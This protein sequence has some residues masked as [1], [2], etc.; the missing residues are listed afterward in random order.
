MPEFVKRGRELT[1]RG[2]HLEA[3]K[4][5][6]LGLLA[7][8]SELDGRLV[9]GQA[10]LSLARFDEVLA[11]MRVALELD[12]LNSTAMA[13]KGEALLGRGD[14]IQA[15]DVLEQ[16]ARF[17]ISDARIDAALARARGAVA[18]GAVLDFDDVSWTRN[19]PEHV[20]YPLAAAAADSSTGATVPGDATDIE[21]APPGLGSERRP[22]IA[23]NRFSAPVDDAPTTIEI[24]PAI[25]GVEVEPPPAFGDAGDDDQE[26][27]VS[28]LIPVDFE[29]ENREVRGFDSSFRA[30]QNEPTHG[31]RGRDADDEEGPTVERPSPDRDAPLFLESEPAR[32][33]R[34][35]FPTDRP[36][37]PPPRTAATFDAPPPPRSP[38]PGAP[39]ET[40]FPEDE[41]GVSKIELLDDETGMPRSFA[42]EPAR[43]RPVPR[44]VLE[45]GGDR[46][47]SRNE[48]M[49]TIRVGLG[50]APDPSRP[51]VTGGGPP[52]RRQRAAPPT[53]LV[54]H[55]GIRAAVGP[56]RRRLSFPVLIALAILLVGGGVSGGVAL[57]SWRTGAQLEAAESRARE[58][59][60]SG[61]YL[62]HLR[63]AALLERALELG[64]NGDLEAL[65]A[66]VEATLHDEFGV[67]EALDATRAASLAGADGDAARARRALA[68]GDA[69]AA[70]TLA[71]QIVAAAPER[72]EGHY[73]R[74]R[75]QV[76][77]GR[78][79]EA[80]RSLA[81]AAE[82]GGTSPLIAAQ[83]AAVERLAGDLDAAMK[84]AGDGDEPALVIE[85]ARALAVA[86]DLGSA[87]EPEASLQLLRADA[88]RPP[89]EQRI[90]VAPRQ[91]ALA[92]L[93]LAEIA[94]ARGDGDRARSEL[95]AL[96]GERSP[97]PAF[98]AA[99]GQALL[100]AG[101]EAGAASQG[102]RL[103]QE[104]P[105]SPQTHL[106]AARLA[107]RTG[108]LAGAAASIEALPDPEA[109]PKA[110]SLRGELALESGRL[111]EAAA[112]LDKALAASPGLAEAVVARARIDL[113]RGEADVALGRLESAPPTRAR[114]MVRVRALRLAGKIDEARQLLV[115]LGAGERPDA[116]L[117]LARLERAASGGAKALAAYERAVKIGPA[118]VRARLERAELMLD[119]G[120][121]K[122][123]RAALEALAT[124]NPGD[125]TVLLGA[126]RAR[127]VMG[128][129]G[130]AQEHIDAAAALSATPTWLLER[131]RGRS[132]LRQRRY[133]DAVAAL[134][135]A[136]AAAP[137][138]ADTRLLIMEAHLRTADRAG[139][140]E[141]VKEASG[142]LSGSHVL[143]LLRGIE[144][145]LAAEPKQAVQSFQTALRLL[146]ERA[147]KREKARFSYWLGRSYEAAGDFDRARAALRQAV[148]L[149]PIHADAWLSLGDVEV[150]DG[151][152]AEAIEHYRRSSAL[153]PVANPRSFFSLG[154][155]YFSERRFPQALEALEQYLELAPDGELAATAREL[156]AEMR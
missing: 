54:R 45:G 47:R 10:L 143:A 109:S 15:V 108:D 128:D 132:L 69:L 93:A 114:E 56:P 88:V 104:W 38:G 62:D 100:A 23:T 26:L 25:E 113:A 118:N 20:G 16:A 107:L 33:K 63:A 81:G 60:A 72:P 75:A 153:D 76:A 138:D 96:A 1:E 70:L 27:S 65:E 2:K 97:D 19:Y 3:V 83:A 36:R 64:T 130:G 150:Q 8:P 53:G 13:L 57:R 135:R 122:E 31:Y 144:S 59:M 79:D 4:V 123:A 61:N 17:A 49:R 119:E 44:G 12:G 55:S 111:E 117:E 11:E 80:R 121:S 154:E 103:L 149:D 95:A 126:A 110:L 92:T 66:R 145:L 68:T 116:A 6:R 99:L 35:G 134:E 21:P 156:I 84:L 28:D 124:E 90:G 125:P 37:L 129:P 77:L 58:L 89:T 98:G 85:R 82:K 155:L 74:G 139:G 32:P 142:P 73:L 78:L 106:F 146:P 24:D 22:P 40:L 136:A 131:E 52:P 112:D 51:R 18:E 46:D 105:E 9:L 7:H 14:P 101:D 152:A 133:G 67:G 30:G 151:K 127:T 5:C 94:L 50:M 91:A 86:A 34:S 147:S 48:D 39:L 120:L 148:Q 29:P 137:V 102:K 42:K 140:R 71:D 141:A 41:D 87:D 43:E 115:T